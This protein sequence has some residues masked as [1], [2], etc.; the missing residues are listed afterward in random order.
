LGQLIAKTQEIILGDESPRAI[1]HPKIAQEEVF[2]LF[3]DLTVEPM[4]VQKLLD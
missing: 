1:A 3:P 4:T 2:C